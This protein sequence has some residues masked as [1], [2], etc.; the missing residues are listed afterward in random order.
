MKKAKDY[1]ADFKA[2]P[3]DKNLV[4]IAQEFVQEIN[5]L[6]ETRHVNSNEAMFS[7]FDEQDRK[8]RAFAR[9]VGSN[10]IRPDGFEELMKRH[11]PEVHL[12]WRG[13][14]RDIDRPHLGRRR[15]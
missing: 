4:S 5:E 15:R 8:W 13:L 1:A 3:T 7:I 14:A 12:F 9:L 2:N 11:F 6:A 10:I